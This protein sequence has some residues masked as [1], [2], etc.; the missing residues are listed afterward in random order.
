MRM[1]WIKFINYWEKGELCLIFE[2]E[3]QCPSK[4]LVEKSVEP[5]S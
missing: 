5:P 2:S 3:I 4:S 1:G